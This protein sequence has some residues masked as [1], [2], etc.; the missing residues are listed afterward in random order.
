MPGSLKSMTQVQDPH[1]NNNR[2]TQTKSCCLKSISLQGG[3]GGQPSWN[4][5]VTPTQN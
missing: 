4:N 1:R 5:P 3:R 2:K